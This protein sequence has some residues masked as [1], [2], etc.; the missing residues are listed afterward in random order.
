MAVKKEVASDF[1]KGVGDDFHIIQRLIEEDSY[2]ELG[3][4][5]MM[6]HFEKVK[7]AN[8]IEMIEDRMKSSILRHTGDN[9]KGRK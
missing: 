6:C 5:Q 1:L 4:V 2:K 7:L 8:F 3:R 9:Q